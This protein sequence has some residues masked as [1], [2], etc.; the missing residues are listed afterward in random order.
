VPYLVAATASAL[1]LGRPVPAGELHAYLSGRT[2]SACGR[3]V[4]SDLVTFDAL[5]WSARP[6]GLAVCRVCFEIAH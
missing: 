2:I 4:G 1:R 6:L 5:R 3:E